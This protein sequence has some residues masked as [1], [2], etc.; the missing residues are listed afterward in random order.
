MTVVLKQTMV[1]VFSALEFNLTDKQ[2]ERLFNII[3]IAYA[4][5]EKEV[6]GEG[7]VRMSREALR[8]HIEDD[9]ILIAMISGEIVGGIRY[10]EKEPGIWTFGL[11]GAAFEH[12]GK[13]IGRTLIAEVEKKAKANDGKEM[14]IEI[15]R[16]IDID[17]DFKVKFGKLV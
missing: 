10:Y 7:Y 17:T 1:V 14:S 5:T 2:F 15:L 12:K 4:E 9:Q 8:Q 13:G 16:A 3:R 6:W 11:L